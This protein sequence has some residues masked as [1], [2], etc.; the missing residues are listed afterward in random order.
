M[1]S[2]FSSVSLRT[3]IRIAVALMWAISGLM[4][5]QPKIHSPLFVSDILAPPAE[6]WQPLGIQRLLQAADTLWLKAPMIWPDVIAALEIGGAFVI[7]WGH[8]TGRTVASFVLVIWS[9]IVWGVAEGFGNLFNGTGSLL[10]GTPG[11]AFLYAMAT[12]LVIMPSAWWENRQLVYRVR[13]G[14]GWLWIMM[15]GLQGLPGAGFWHG[16]RLAEVFGLVT[17]D[18]SEPSWLQASINDGVMLSFHHPLMTNLFLVL[19]MLAVGIAWLK[20][21]RYAFGLSLVV[22]AIIWIVP[23]ACGGIWTGIAPTP[24]MILPLLIFIGMARDDLMGQQPL[25]QRI[26][27]K[28]S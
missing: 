19:I 22:M 8:N 26:K 2:A 20:R 15:A 14:L 23:Q 25:S 5:L 18:G 24:G 13:Q 10:T 16:P 3:K 21:W 17:M 6:A 27:V 1:D 7:A 12:L 4:M 28:P 9:V 11:T